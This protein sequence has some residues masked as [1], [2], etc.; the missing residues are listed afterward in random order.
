M[1]SQLETSL[2]DMKQHS[3]NLMSE[4]ASSIEMASRRDAQQLQS[5][6]QEGF[7]QQQPTL[8]GYTNL[9]Q[10]SLADLKEESTTICGIAKELRDRPHNKPPHSTSSG[11][12]NMDE[13]KET[14]KETVE[15]LVDP[16]NM[17]E[18]QET[19][20]QT[21]KDLRLKETLEETAKKLVIPGAEQ[22]DMMCVHSM[23]VSGH[24]DVGLEKSLKSAYCFIGSI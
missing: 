4:H 24:N 1:K 17:D 15:N 18:L 6:L 11:P 8:T 2:K 10:T 14:L 16:F 9:F 20:K 13:L 7:A 23:E 3:T 22:Y 12:V 19:L 5:V 21:V